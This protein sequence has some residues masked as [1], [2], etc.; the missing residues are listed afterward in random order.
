MGLFRGQKPCSSRPL[1]YLPSVEVGL[2]RMNRNWF[3]YSVRTLMGSA[4][5]IS[6]TVSP[7]ARCTARIRYPVQYQA[8]KYLDVRSALGLTI[9][10]RRWAGSEFPQLDKKHLTLLNDGGVFKID[11]PMS[12]S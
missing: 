12:K 7:L 6:N 9:Q 4:G 8:G 11:F 10:S 1:G 5:T 3:T 2:P